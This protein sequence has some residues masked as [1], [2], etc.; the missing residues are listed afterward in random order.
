[1][2]FAAIGSAQD[3]PAV[4]VA[5]FGK[6]DDTPVQLYTLTNR[7]GL[8][9]R[10]T[11]FGAIV[12]ELHVP[13]RAGTLADIVLGFEDLDSYVKGHPYF[14]AIVG[15]VANRIGNAEFTLGGTRY[16][17]EAND[18][19][20]HLHGGRKGW[21]KVVWNARPF[22]T[23]AGPALELTYVSKDGEEGYRVP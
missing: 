19:P 8:V 7:H 9:A 14:G 21:D 10:I 2:A 12:T 3:A 1:M 23:P 18:R 22:E 13:D 11:N 16:R 15:R 5:P 6:L 4:A 20:H 17:L